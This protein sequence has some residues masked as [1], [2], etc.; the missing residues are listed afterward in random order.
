MPTR[1]LAPKATWSELASESRNKPKAAI[2]AD[3]ARVNRGPK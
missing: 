1:N 3:P 2:T